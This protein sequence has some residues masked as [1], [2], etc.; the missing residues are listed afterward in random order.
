M[1]AAAEKS[2]TTRPPAITRA[3][4]PFFGRKGGGDF[5]GPAL[6]NNAVQTKMAVNRPGDVFEQEAD[7]MS[8]RVMR[9][10]ADSPE[11]T[12]RQSGDNLGR[13]EEKSQRRQE[14]KV[15]RQPEQNAGRQ[16]DNVQRQGEEKLQKQSAEMPQKAEVIHRFKREEE[17]PHHQ[18]L[19]NLGE[20]Q[21]KETTGG[22]PE[23][24]GPLESAIKTQ[25]TGGQPLQND[26]R[27]EMESHFGADF[28]T[29]RI[30]TG[31]EAEALNTQLK[32][33]AFTY[34]NHI[35]FSRDQFRPDSRDGKQLLAHEL[36]HTIQQGQA[37]RRKP[38]PERP[39]D[40]LHRATKPPATEAVTSSE[41]VDLS[42]GTFAPSEKVQA[43]IEAQGHKGLEVR[44]IVKGVTDEGRI[45]VRADRKK[46]FHSIGRGSM[47]VKAAWADQ[48][49]GLHLNI[50]LVQSEIKDGFASVKASG[51]NAHDWVRSLQK[52]TEVLGGLGLKVEN[53]PKPVNK[54][55]AGKL[56]LGVTNL[57]V[58]VGGFLDASFNF[59]AENAARP[60]V[61]AS[62][63]INVKGIAKGQLKLDNTKEK[64]AG[65]ISLGIEYKSFVGNA[66]IKYN[67]DGTV[68]IGGKAGYNADRLSGT[69]EFVST[70]LET[71]NNFARDA[72]KAAGGK[73]KVQEAPPPAPV[74]ASKPGAK[75]RGL[76]ATGQLA[77]HLTEWFAG[78]VFVVVDA[79]GDVTVIGKIAPPGE[80]ELM[81]QRDWDIEFFKL[82]AKAYYGIP[83][84]GNIN[85]F[86]NV[87]LRGIA[88]LGPAKIYN[89]EILGTYSTDPEIQKMIQISGSINI[90]A[91]AGVRLRAEGGAGIEILDHDIK[92]GVGIQVDVGVKS[93]V[94][95]RPTIGFRDPGVFYISG[96]LVMVAQPV[97]G[98]G[99]D[100]FIALETPW[101]SPLSDDR[102]TW[103]LFTKEWPLGDPIGISAEMKEYVLGSKKIPE[104]ELK[105][106]EFDSSKFMSKMVDNDLP[107]KSGKAGA[108]QGSFKEDG[109]VKK[110][111]IPPKKPAP[112]K[113]EG[114][115][116]K[117]LPAPKAG[118]SAKPDP[119]GVKEKDNAKLLQK[120]SKLLAA[121]KGKGPFSRSELN[122]EIEKIKS[123]ASGIAFVIQQKENKWLVKPKVGGKVGKG[124]ELGKSKEADLHEKIGREVARRLSQP[125]RTGS[126]DEARKET[127]AVAQEL[128][129]ESNKKLEKPIKLSVRFKDKANDQK[130][131]DIDFNIHIGPNDFDVEGAARINKA[132]P[133]P[134]TVGSWI[135][136]IK[137]KTYEQVSATGSVSRR[138][139][140]TGEEQE[141]GFMTRKPDGGTGS[142]RYAD[143]GVEWERTDFK[144]PSKYVMPVGGA[145]FVLQ[146]MYRGSE[147]IRPN[148]YRDTSSSR[149]NM[150]KSK[151]P[152]LLHPSIPGHF[153]SE[154][155]S[156]EE[157]AEG[158][159]QTFNGKAVIPNSAAS[160]D[161]DPPI[162]DHWTNKK[163][164]DMGQAGREKWNAT[165]TN[166]KLMS[167]KLNRRLGSRGETYTDKV[168]ITFTGP[169]D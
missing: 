111:E 29:V 15:G 154:A 10:G 116:P 103:P 8:E 147:Y 83:V 100:F 149:D 169:G 148:F 27:R 131:N 156:A 36:T 93:Y 98:L 87:S 166:Y 114:K 80:I 49:G 48:L 132:R 167:W 112:K 133:V 51:G 3:E 9:A 28:S 42:S 146:P 65:Q 168:G 54:F 40:I 120:A 47:P 102:W 137:A 143:E 24:G 153:L 77:F 25:A 157:A 14:E 127:E 1:K 89:I 140:V 152:A 106:P 56:T 142:W 31:P 160:P 94:D 20:V 119:K 161:H 73:E 39:E 66:L 45:K 118:K 165:L 34:K 164:N 104:I 126:Y 5:F 145:M 110:P 61:E 159:T 91:Y 71:A 59:T 63:D 107:G 44:V 129:R 79:K 141:L 16:P 76:A 144:H 17:G 32:A 90:S 19:T 108:G 92:F 134:V 122:H 72:I 78:T 128:I 67:P 75:K 26:L 162:S 151:L 11:K 121:L 115:A 130:D 57:K 136:N 117:K 64:L 60:V 74:P 155:P 95:A 113:A 84:V 22:A 163:G 58:E 46:N 38:P 99:G 123:Q 33:R 30:H 2:P 81:K 70:D 86:A 69:I 55:E 150:I 4:A 105:K 138:T 88:S 52:T 158:Y 35:F 13:G 37:I 6:K 43:E 68:D 50:R 139:K 125:I 85:V 124:V 109:T 23:I 97:L 41:V 7:N 21:R 96:T 12:Q 135:K 101:W 62:A 18:S 53:L 82:E